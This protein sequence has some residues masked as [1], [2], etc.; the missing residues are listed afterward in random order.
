MGSVYVPETG[1]TVCFGHFLTSHELQLVYEVVEI[2][3]KEMC[4]LC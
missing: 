3:F 1:Q 2:S 4:G